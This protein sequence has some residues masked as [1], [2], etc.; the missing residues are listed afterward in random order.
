MPY[1]L[2]QFKVELIQ[3]KGHWKWI[4]F[5]CPYPWESKKR[6]NQI[7]SSRSH[8]CVT[9]PSDGIN[10]K[11]KYM[12]EQTMVSLL[13]WFL[14]FSCAFAEKTAAKRFINT[15]KMSVTCA[16]FQHF[17]KFEFYHVH[18][19]QLHTSWNKNSLLERGGGG[20]GG[21]VS[22]LK[23]LCHSSNVVVRTGEVKFSEQTENVSKAAIW[24][25]ISLPLNT[26]KCV[27][28]NI[29]NNFHNIFIMKLLMY[30]RDFFRLWLKK[31]GCKRQFN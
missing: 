25:I 28:E 20:G 11:W 27:S 16:P 8:S 24:M 17:T 26:C 4:L 7:Y 30:A 5:V 29:N 22:V 18:V 19:K 31:L 1:K 21:V 3:L 6:F 10:L 15:I 14:S 9:N 13:N 2:K 12:N 23:C